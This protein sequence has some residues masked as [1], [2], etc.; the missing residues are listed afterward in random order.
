MRSRHS[1]AFTL[2][3]LLVVIAII[4]ILA[5][6]LVPALSKAKA[7]ARKIV[8]INNTKQLGLGSLLYAQDNK[9]DLVG[10]S[11]NPVYLP[12][13]ALSDRNA[14]DDDFNWLYPTYVPAFGTYICPTTRHFIRTNT[15]AKP[16]GGTA[17]EDLMNNARGNMGPG[18]SYEIFGVLGG[19]GKKSED[20]VNRFTIRKYVD[21]PIGARPGASQVFLFADA[22][23]VTDPRD[24][25]NWPDS[26]DNHGAE[27]TVF[28]FCDGHSEFV[29]HSRFLRV[30]NLGSDSD[31]AP[32]PSLP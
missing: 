6:L 17:I 11:W 9:G 31:R 5:G 2:I 8:C 1:K 28:A 16:L 27:G 12:H 14:A 25:N 19:I 3:E 15:I 10:T 13:S 22:D 24:R 32:P 29:T 7:R 21:G 18:T 20:L 26:M 4:A 23:D 30:W